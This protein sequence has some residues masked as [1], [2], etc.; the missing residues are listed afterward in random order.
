[1]LKPIE[2]LSVSP[3]VKISPVLALEVI[4]SPLQELEARALQFAKGQGAFGSNLSLLQQATAEPQHN[5]SS[6]AVVSPTA[7]LIDQILKQAEIAGI[8]ARFQAASVVTSTPGK[9]N[10]VA[11]DLKNAVSSTGLFYE[12]HLSGYIEGYR[13]LTEIRQEPQN[14]ASMS[15]HNLLPQQ[16]AILENQ[17]FSWHG[18]I[19]PNQKMDWDIHLPDKQSSSDDG[20][21]ADDIQKSI[22]SDLTLHLPNLGKVT[23]KISLHDGRVHIGLLAEESQ[24]VTTLKAESVKLLDA[25]QNKGQAVDGLHILKDKAETHG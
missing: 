18:E 6:T 25:I 7:F 23:A 20:H 2:N 15:A 22:A 8:P 19:W 10:L 12:S 24:T 4:G 14:Q 11:Q 9:P 1:M 3:L 21:Q 16:L 17:R 5:N 13:T